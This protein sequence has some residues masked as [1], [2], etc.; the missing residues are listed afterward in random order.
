[1]P[2]IRLRQSLVAV[3]LCLGM[4]GQGTM[5]L[6]GTTGTLSGNV[7][8]SAGTAL[9]SAQVTAAS[10][11]QTATVT[12][13][14]T[15]HFVFLALAPDTYTVSIKAAGYDA[16]ATQGVSIAADNER[17]LN[18][19]AVKTTQTIG[20]VVGRANSD[21]VRPGT[22]SDVYS[23][24]AAQQAKLAAVGGGGNLNTAW[25]AI[26]S[27]PGVSVAPN[28][29]GYIG[30]AS[31][32]SIRGG[33]YDQIGYEI[34]G[35]PV[36][37]SFDNYPSGPASSL[38][39][40]EVQVY[41]GGAPAN[42]NAQ[43]I[44]GFINQVIKTGTYPGF[45]DVEL[46]LGAPSFYNK[47]SFEFGGAT[48]DRNFSYYVAYDGYNQNFRYA[49]QFNGQSLQNLYGPA[50]APCGAG[51]ESCTVGG[52]P[53]GATSFALGPF[54]AF[55]T[56]KVNARDFVVNL[57]IG[58]PHKNGTK[59]DI[60]LLGVNNYFKT[61]YY[62][63]PN[64]LGGANYLNDI[65]FGVPSFVDGYQLNS[66]TG[67]P[68]A[69][70]A[71]SLASQYFFPG[72][73]AHTFGGPIPGNLEDDF[74]NN[75]GIIKAQ[76]THALGTNALVKVYGYTY[77]SNWLNTGP[78]GTVANY[79][80]PVSPD[81]ELSAHTRGVAL[82]FQ[83]QINAQNFLSIDGSYTTASTVRDNNTQ[84][85]NGLYGPNSVNART[86]AAVLVS[87]ANPTSGLCY[88]SSGVAVSCAYGNSATSAQFVTLQQ[89]YNNTIAPI[90]AANC[91]GAPCEYL[92][93]GNGQY[94]TY[95]TVTPL[96]SSA[97]LTDT[98]KPTSQLSIDLGI[99]Y[100]RYQFQGGDTSGGPARA[101]FYNAFNLDNCFN[102]ATLL[103]VSK[104]PT[105][106][107]PAGTT[108][109]NVTNPSGIVSQGYNE[110]QPRF[111]VTFAI[112]PR[113]VIRGSYG[114]FAEAPNAAF[115][116]Y[117]ALQSNA[118]ALL[119]GTYGFQKFGFTTPNHAVVP[120]T[121]DNLDFS[122]EHQFPDQLSIK[123]SP[124]YRKTQNQ[125]QQ[126]YLN[127]QTNFVSG[128]N[129]GNQTS[130]GIEFELDK[131]NFAAN[132][133]AAKLSL[134]YQYSTIKYSPLSNGSTIIDPLNA[135]IKQYN[136]YTSYCAANPTNA[137]C[138]T[139]ST[140]VAAAPCYTAAGAPDN[141]CLAGSIAN[142]YWQAPVQGL[143]DPGGAYPTFDI[144]PAGIGSS[145]NAYG[146]PYTGVLLV[147]Y[148][149]DKFAVTPVLQFNGG[150]RYGAPASTEGIAPDTCTAG[151]AGGLIAGDGRYQYGA[152]GGAPFDST[153][154]GT[155]GQGIP[156]TYTGKFDTIG[157]FVEPSQLLFHTQLTYE[158]SKQ[159]SF[160][161]NFS[162]IVNTC[163]G[164]TKT[165]FTVPNACGYSL[166]A[167]GAYGG[168]GNVYNP[169][170]VI[171]PY[172]QHPYVPVYSGYP[173]NAFPF[174]VYVSAKIHL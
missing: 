83:D 22:S 132:G 72:V 18:I 173:N 40:Q 118:P 95:N 108:P 30:A 35:V 73:P 32:I 149:H 120:P 100:D 157:A 47:A 38:G 140:G 123:I 172:V 21:L 163:F 52:A 164:G 166:V 16:S 125:I 160:I 25:S 71:T 26:A 53:T 90:T 10:P 107:C 102:P 49:D 159:L 15:G 158:V 138:G 14:R 79:F 146:Q 165:G 92:T 153:S 59:D 36:N 115:E 82:T 12:T 84:F 112:D 4:V 99:R 94:A 58:L 69:A 155:L 64:D 91:G 44:S 105:A 23:I 96:F 11:S 3:L 168:I 110:W 89:I 135:G 145:V 51:A 5:V 114:R 124:F 66:P 174:N 169:G 141:A 42:A 93:V 63:S 33:D 167:N 113:T 170:D 75:Q 117:D 171:Q 103:F 19:S 65:G 109:A 104:S 142:P 97:S 28:Q 9:A 119:Y 127:Q 111:G 70:N 80:G 41:T 17:T 161:A 56:S 129:V 76:Y 134:A 162:N 20:R 78:N 143:L 37:R 48:A 13:D 86:A 31:T 131:G 54:Q 139:T 50:I 87:S 27:V 106:A 152:P 128:L 45:A 81:Y 147:Q 60:Q 98:F 77:Y 151:L 136:A 1:M 8:D 7:T 74:V 2:T 55:D 116:Q 68:L 133:F 150:Q 39:Q 126:F 62:G 57:H 67:V 29:T 130:Q 46:S 34:D 137:K 144:F 122:L 43:G 24:N 154:C 148:K 85:L 6:A 61:Y 156:D 101:L 121:S 88:S